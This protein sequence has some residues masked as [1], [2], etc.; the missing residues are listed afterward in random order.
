MKCFQREVTNL[1]SV[2]FRAPMSQSMGAVRPTPWT[3]GGEMRKM[4]G[5]GT[6]WYVKT[7]YI[8]QVH[9]HTLSGQEMG[10]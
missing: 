8:M 5:A 6:T 7:V 1:R 4:H 10:L 9:S 3:V 2:E